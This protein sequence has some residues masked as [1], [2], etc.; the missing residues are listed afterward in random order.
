MAAG[1]FGK[2]HQDIKP[3]NR[4]DI[5]S[6]KFTPDRKRRNMEQRRR[7]EEQGGVL[8]STV[9]DCIPVTGGGSG[10]N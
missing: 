3:S 1:L 2:P 4:A 5:L 7:D 10:G 9:I 8:V 6:I